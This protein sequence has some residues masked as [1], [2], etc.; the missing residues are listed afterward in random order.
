ML[1]EE[2]SADT[3]VTADGSYRAST[4]VSVNVFLIAVNTSSCEG[5]HRQTCLLRTK[6][7]ALLVD[8]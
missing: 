1:Y 5:P 6:Y 7:V 2:A 3:F 8:E 4:V